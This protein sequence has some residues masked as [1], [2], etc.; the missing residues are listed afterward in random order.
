MKFISNAVYG[1]GFMKEYT[2]EEIKNEPMFFNCGF[3]FAF[4]HGGPITKE[5]LTKFLVDDHHSTRNV[6]VDSRVH[7][8]MPGWYPCIPGWHHDDIARTRKDGQPNYKNL[9]YKSKH[10]STIIGDAS[11]TEFLFG[12]I[13]L[14]IPK[15][16]RTIYKDWNDEIENRKAE[17]E[18]FVRPKLKYT[19][20]PIATNRL[21][22]FDWQTFHRGMPA[23]KDGWRMFI[24]A[25]WDTE[26]KRTNE[27]RRQSQVYMSA[28]EAGW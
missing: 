24:R 20:Q 16:G 27:I 3:D 4:D 18:F 12:E 8:L 19:I 22:Y 23:T 15:L 1:N 5:F 28:L 26:R 13:N 2:Q 25:S 11:V 6:I 7:M 21:V 14:A 10:A 9:A 17:R